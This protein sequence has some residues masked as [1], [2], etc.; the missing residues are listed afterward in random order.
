M[1]NMMNAMTS[2]DRF[3]AAVR[4][5]PADRVPVSPD[6]SNSIPASRTGLPYWEIY[7]EGHYPLWKAYLEACDHFGTEAWVASAFG[8]PFVCDTPAVVT[9]STLELDHSRDAMMKST[10]Y[11]TPDGDMTGLEICFR[12]NPSSPV[13]KPVTDP[14]EDRAKAA[15]FFQCP[16]RID[17][18]IFETVR[19]Q[20]LS[21]GQAFG[22]CMGY[23]GFHSWEGFVDQ[24]VATLSL[25][26]QDCPEILEE[27]FDRHMAQG[28][29]QME[30]LLDAAP[31]YILFGGS[32]TITMASPALARKY[33]LPALKKWSAMAKSRQIPTMVHSC[34]K[35]RV[36]VEMLAT[37]TDVNLINPLEIPPMGDIDLAEVKRT[38]GSKIA[39]MGNLHTTDVMLKGDVARVRRAALQ[40]LRDAGQGGGFVLSTGDQ[41]GRD[42]PRENIFALVQVAKE[43]G[44]YENGSLPALEDVSALIQS[45]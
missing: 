16:D 22:C 14:V 33:A 8:A 43:Y 28:T 35:S 42:T 25:M 27:W 41:C 5:L 24:G 38:H 6:F 11:R 13:R 17:R 2:R 21:R 20:C 1:D 32:G 19:Q 3:L 10:R 29:R 37:E 39:L 12:D 4:N 15:H 34:G 7:F 30:L 23:P 44:H 40:A 26:L 9:E 18:E 36:L 45:V 31:D